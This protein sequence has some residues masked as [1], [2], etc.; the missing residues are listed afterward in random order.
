MRVC[1]L[2]SGSS[3]N[4]TYIGH[5]DTNILIDAGISRKKIC[6][7]LGEIGIEASKLNAILVT[8]LHSDHCRHVYSMHQKYGTKVYL[9]N[10]SFSNVKNGFCNYDVSNIQNLQKIDGNTQIGSL[11]I[12]S[13]PLPHSSPLNPFFESGETLGFKFTELQSKNRCRTIGY[14]TDLGHLPK[15]A[16]EHLKGC[17]TIILES[18]HSEK[19]VDEAL[20]LI[21][22]RLGDRTH[23]S[24][25]RSR[26][27]I[28]SGIR[29]RWV[30]SDY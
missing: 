21:S 15:H 10:K 22:G 27:E 18:N 24:F 1:V 28:G 14:A 2:A 13:F 12:S 19:L 16:E 25:G 30:R 8:H 11:D 6:N 20:M 26:T 5:E 29:E 17:N 3:G 4:C 23:T 9:G 7:R